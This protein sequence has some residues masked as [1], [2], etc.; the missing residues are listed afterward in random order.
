MLRPAALLAAF[1]L[2]TPALAQTTITI[3]NHGTQVLVA[4]NSFPVGADGDVVDD[5][6]GSLQEDEV[7]PGATGTIRLSGD[8][9]LVEMYFRYAGQAEGDDDQ[10]FR[11]DTCQ[12]HRFVLR[13]PA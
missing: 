3:V 4:V 6:I 7:G 8:C 10:V 13:D 1:L 2:A 11:V 5:N 9:G 12:A